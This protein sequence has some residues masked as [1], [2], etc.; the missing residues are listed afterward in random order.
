MLPIARR[1]RRIKG[2]A[3]VTGAWGG[4]SLP[5]VEVKNARPTVKTKKAWAKAA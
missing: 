2:T 5:S 1:A 4:L 3:S